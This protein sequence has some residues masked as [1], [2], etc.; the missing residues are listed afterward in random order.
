MINLIFQINK[1]HDPEKV[2]P[3]S[4]AFFSMNKKKEWFEDPFV[5]RIMQ[6][7]DGASVISGYV[8]KDRSGEVIPPEYLST[9]TKTAVCVYFFPDMVFN[10]TQMGDNALQ[11]VLELSQCRDITLL[12]YRDLPYFAFRGLS[13]CKDYE[14]VS[15]ADDGEFY[16]C[17]DEWLEEIYND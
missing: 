4:R 17:M 6:E 8:L 14:P 12:V 11:F 16:E 10:A 13:V 7:V 9:G 3:D 2:Q 15:F 5:Q 1:A